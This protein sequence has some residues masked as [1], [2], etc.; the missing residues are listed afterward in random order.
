MT[1]A[2]FWLFEG[3]KF[4]YAV[5]RIRRRSIARSTL[6]RRVDVIEGRQA[7]QNMREENLELGNDTAIQSPPRR[8]GAPFELIE[9]S[10]SPRLPTMASSG[11]SGGGSSIT[12]RQ[13]STRFNTRTALLSILAAAP[14]AMAQDCISLSGSTQCPAFSSASIS[15]DSTLVGFLYVLSLSEDCR[16][17]C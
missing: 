16:F 17:D 4:V 13:G 5:P 15:T 7:D 14:V 9:P 12:R 2:F 11:G 6:K 8:N 3:R 10:Q 1:R